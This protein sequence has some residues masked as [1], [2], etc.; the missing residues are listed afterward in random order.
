MAPRSGKAKGRG[1]SGNRRAA[2]SQQGRGR[3]PANSEDINDGVPEIFKEMLSE[4]AGL[5][6]VADRPLKRR[7]ILG[8][9]PQHYPPTVTEP[10]FHGPAATRGTSSSP[11]VPA[12]LQTI[13]DES[14]SS[15]SDFEWEDVALQPEQSSPP[16]D[17][18]S[19]EAEKPLNIVIDLKETPVK[20]ARTGRKP[21]SSA[22]KL[23]RLSIHKMHVM[24]L[25]Y[26]GF[27]RNQWCNDRRA[28]VCATTLMLQVKI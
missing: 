23:M 22:E 19:D 17:D 18:Q 24:Y 13:I 8:K 2:S 14:E 5:S 27:Y 20:R 7:R 15:E 3:K 1:K 28:Q 9:P 25:I 4:E 11:Q 12:R 16:A 6:A 21:I 26:H 10:E